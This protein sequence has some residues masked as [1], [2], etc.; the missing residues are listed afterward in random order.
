MPA[1]GRIEID[2]QINRNNVTRELRAL[3]RELNN[4]AN[5]MKLANMKAM[6][7]FQKK[8]IETQKDMF[9]LAQSMGNYTGTTKEFMNQVNQL[10]AQYKKAS[11][12]MI[13]ANKMIAA[14]MI[15]QAGYMMNM[16]TQAEKI[17][18]GYNRMGNPL[19][20]VNNLSL[21]I[22]S[23]L[24]K[25]A[26]AGNASVLALK[27]LGPNASMKALRDEQMKIIAGQM[28]FQQVA[29]ASMVTGALVYG[30]LHKAAMKANK[31]YAESFKTMIA[32]LRKAFEPMV[33]VFAEVMTKVYDFVN[34]IAVMMIRFNE[35]HP[36]LAK[37]IQ[38]IMLLIPALT[39]LLSPLAVG[40]T[41]VNS[42]LAAWAS[43]A[44][45]VMPLITGLA[46]I[47]G[48]VLLVAAAIVGLVAGIRALWKNSE[49]FRN[50][51][52]S[53]VAALQ[54]FAQSVLNF[55]KYLLEIVKT[56]NV[57]NAWLDSLPKGLQNIAQMVGQAISTIREHFL[58]LFD[59]VIAA[60]HG[61]FSQLQTIFASIIPSLIGLL[62]GGI[63]GLFIAA[64]RFIP[65]IRDG[66]LSGTGTL[67]QTINN[68]VNTIVTFLTTQLPVFIQKGIEIIQ[69]IISG[70]ITAIP[71]ISNAIL[72]IL[73]SIVQIITQLLPV[74]L[75][76]GIQ[77]ITTLIQGI[78]QMLPIVMQTAL[79]LINSLIFT[80]L[81]NLPMILGV[82][83]Q[84]VMTLIQGIVQ[85]LPTIIQ[86][87]MQLV[88]TITQT[89]VTYL[90]ILLQTG[91]Q[92]IIALINGIVQMMPTFLNMFIDL[93]IMI[94][95]MIIRNLPIIINAG[96][97][98]LTALIDGIT[99][100][101]PQLLTLIVNLV[102]QVA[103]MVI[104]NLPLIIDAGVKILTSLIDGIVKMLPQLINLAINLIIKVANTLINNLPTIINAGVKL[105]IALVNGII[106]SLPQLISA[107][108][109]LIVALS[110]AI[111]RNLPTII[112]AGVQLL[113]ALIKGIISM[114]WQLGSSV[115]NDIIPEIVDN[116]K[117]V[118]LIKVGKDIIKGLIKG[119]GSMA[120]AVK[121]KII[122]VAGNIKDRIMGA[123]GIHSP[124][125]W[126]RD[127]I[128][129]NMMLG[130]QLGIEDE[131]TSTLKKVEEMLSWIM[132]D[133]LVANVSPYVTAPIAERAIVASEQSSKT[134]TID[135]EKLGQAMSKYLNFD[136]YLDGERITQSVNTHNAVNVA[137]NKMS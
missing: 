89:I 69:N 39:L 55:G 80:I 30:S 38:G 77:I 122:E 48:T 45:M 76:A 116:L 135:Y 10:G 49:G 22:A 124:S 119:I 31:G 137:I 3:Q 25:L 8:L 103:N 2:T 97:Q 108:L 59:A 64:S 117:N 112:K 72:T 20:T 86:M 61:D 93:I 92:I 16:S 42:F 67:T 129:K 90:P 109:R 96:I 17:A 26:N 120:G 28:R 134:S 56:G 110:G 133:K 36:I 9:S 19:R 14:S 131:K 136:F 106:K 7:P 50:T 4:M 78:I 35:A 53:V 114:V 87:F 128:G 104:K 60:F 21:S 125:R 105:L 40:A 98:I 27:E 57:M 5:E 83:V 37:V 95:N 107:A 84:M 44:P 58:S 81:G 41:M 100:I 118:D 115:K 99:Q 32:N 111:I 70:I 132:P 123:L 85:M 23:G 51:V 88:M 1:D 94:G 33:Q 13:N 18:Q 11:D 73:G 75:Q 6:L 101:L 82:G 71:Q 121:D 66:I 79:Q 130:W 52:L 62:V 102:I 127:M 34:A 74:L 126:M 65:A 24:N 63:P 54:A 43:L 68:V 12:N 47:S 29:L 113:L 15:Q 46:A 91:I